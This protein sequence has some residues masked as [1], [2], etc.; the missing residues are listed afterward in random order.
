MGRRS[1]FARRARD[2][3]DTPPEAVRP[4]IRHLPRHSRY[5]EP[6]AG[7]GAIIHALA[8]HARC[9]GASDI[10]PRAEGIAARDALDVTADD[11]VAADAE[12]IITNPPWPRPGSPEPTLSMIKHFAAI[13]PTWMLLPYTFAANRYFAA[14]HPICAKLVVIGRVSWMGNGMAGVDDSA[15]FLFDAQHIGGMRFFPREAA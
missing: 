15:W 2:T 8:D 9:V 1:D 7:K 13:R 14:L 3:Y 4:L 10:A 6:C 11:I 5:W 12:W